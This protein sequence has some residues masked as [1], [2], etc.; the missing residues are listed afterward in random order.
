[1][2]RKEFLDM[3]LYAETGNH[4]R[5]VGDSGHAIGAYQ[6]HGEWMLDWWPDWAWTILAAI[7]RAAL[8]RFTQYHRDGTPRPHTLARD[9]AD[10]YN[11]GHLAP[12]PA[13]DQRINKALETLLIPTTEINEL[14]E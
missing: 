10:E 9:L 7:E 12:D 3:I 2:T 8:E 5:S 1:M 4:P 14:V 11:L 6:Q 13:Y